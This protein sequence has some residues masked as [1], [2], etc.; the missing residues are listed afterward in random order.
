MSNCIGMTIRTLAILI[1]GLTMIL[2]ISLVH[3]GGQEVE[4]SAVITIEDIRQK[5][6][7]SD[8]VCLLWS[9]FLSS[10]G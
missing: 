7:R 4:Q 10:I 6:N 1:I 3:L 2:V 9:V 8:N 5:F